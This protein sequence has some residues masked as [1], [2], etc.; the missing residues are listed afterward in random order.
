MDVKTLSIDFGNTNTVVYAEFQD[1]TTNTLE[2]TAV[3]VNDILLSQNTTDCAISTIPSEV[4]LGEDRTYI[5]KQAFREV[6]K[7]HSSDAYSKYSIHFKKNL[8]NACQSETAADKE[9]QEELMRFG[10]AFLSTLCMYVR[11]EI[12]MEIEST[13]KIPSIILTV[14]VSAP[15]EYR[16]WLKQKIHNN[17]PANS[18]KVLDE[19]TCAAFF[20]NE[21]LKVGDTILVVDIGGSTTDFSLVE[22]SRMSDG[23]PASRIL[24][25]DG[26]R[27]GGADIDRLIADHILAKNELD[28]LSNYSQKSVT[29]ILKLAEKAKKILTFSDRFVDEL[30]DPDLGES[31]SFIISKCELEDILLDSNISS[32]MDEFL[33]NCKQLVD[34]AMFPTAEIKYAAFI[35]GSFIQPFLRHLV[36]NALENAQLP[37]PQ[38]SGINGKESFYAVAYGAIKLSEVKL[39]GQCLANS[40]FL[41]TGPMQE[42][43]FKP[44]FNKGDHYPTSSQDFALGKVEENQTH[45]KFWLAEL[46]SYQDLGDGA[47]YRPITYNGSFY[48]MKLPSDAI[49]GEFRFITRFHIDD[50]LK[51]SVSMYD[52]VH[53]INIYTNLEIGNQRSDLVFANHSGDEHSSESISTGES[54]DIRIRREKLLLSDGRA[55]SY[56]DDLKLCVGHKVSE[57]KLLYSNPDNKFEVEVEKEILSWSLSGWLVTGCTIP[58]SPWKPDHILVLD[59]GVIIVIE[60]KYYQGEWTGAQNG[61]WRSDGKRIRCGTSRGVEDDN[62]LIEVEKSFWATRDRASRLGIQSDPFVMRVVVAPNSANIDGVVLEKDGRLVKLDSLYDIIN[63]AKKKQD[64]LIKEGHKNQPIITSGMVCDAFGIGI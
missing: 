32:K 26:L 14:P 57:T 40:I 4:F 30:Y 3:S 24:A 63:W 21:S 56:Q 11:N 9:A 55:G 36:S 60:D 35:G 12:G 47:A 7:S 49:A 43:N 5:G 29:R 58:G 15:L 28:S 51:I 54:L 22:V 62:P 34:D 10:E 39:K 61:P 48:R 52:E 45:F 17:L 53:G 33:A 27:I 59:N 19:A 41:R 18:I 23:T 1:G 16:G 2:L 8:L 42:V 64:D 46:D 31:I 25:R 13:D 44:L 38:Q 37:S 20:Y 50:E 6:G